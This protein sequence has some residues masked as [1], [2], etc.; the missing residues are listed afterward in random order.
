MYVGSYHTVG[1]LLRSP[2]LDV[3]RQLSGDRTVYPAVLTTS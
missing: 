2:R 1:E 3:T